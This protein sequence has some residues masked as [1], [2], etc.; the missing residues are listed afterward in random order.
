MRINGVAESCETSLTMNVLYDKGAILMKSTVSKLMDDD[1]MSPIIWKQ[2][3]ELN[4]KIKAKLGD[5]IKGKLKNK[6]LD[7]IFSDP[8]VT[9]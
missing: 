8:L 6:E 9:K 1:K 5:Q 2:M 4:K 7:E 3:K